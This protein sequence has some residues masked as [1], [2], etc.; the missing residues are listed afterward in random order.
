[1]P[2]YLTSL[3]LA[4]PVKAVVRFNLDDVELS[5]DA[6]FTAASDVSDGGGD[7]TLLATD[8]RDGANAATSLPS[9]D[10]RPISGRAHAR[11]HV[12]AGQYFSILFVW[13]VLNW[14]NIYPV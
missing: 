12:L 1:M 13:K 11:R 5:G 3:S 8:S 7:A 2:A 10:K 9:V 4:H 6:A 14:I